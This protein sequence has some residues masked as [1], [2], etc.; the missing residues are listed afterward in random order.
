MVACIF[1]LYISIKINKREYNL[2]R[3]VGYVF[4]EGDI[5]WESRVIISMISTAI[6]GRIWVANGL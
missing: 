5:H 2:K 6:L 3:K 1:L 4:V